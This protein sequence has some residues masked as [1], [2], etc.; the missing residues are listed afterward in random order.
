MQQQLKVPSDMPKDP[1]YCKVITNDGA[2]MEGSYPGK[3]LD[4]L[5]DA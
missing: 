3:E 2:T 5:L 1:E 4:V